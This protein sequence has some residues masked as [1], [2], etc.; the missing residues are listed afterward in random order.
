M[1]PDG[2][3]LVLVG[4]ALVLAAATG[5]LMLRTRRAAVRR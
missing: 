4:T 1:G 3:V 2:R 5:G